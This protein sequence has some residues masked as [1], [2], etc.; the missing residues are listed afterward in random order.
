MLAF[1]CVCVLDA[2][3][4]TFCISLSKHSDAAVCCS[5]WVEELIEISSHRLAAS[6]L[7]WR[8][9]ALSF[10]GENIFIFSS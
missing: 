10:S 8:K 3:A 9:D 2:A 4:V 1:I 6:H 5:G 7:T